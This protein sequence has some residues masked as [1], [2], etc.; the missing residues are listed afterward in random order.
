MTKL[1]TADQ[2]LSPEAAAERVAPLFERAELA[3]LELC[4]RIAMAPM[5]RRLAPDDRVP[6]QAI[7][8]YYARRASGGVGLIITEGTHVDDQHAPDSENVPG[9]FNDE[10]ASGWKRVIEAVHSAENTFGSPSRIAVQLWHTGRHAMNPIGP[11]PIPVQKRDGGYKDT[12]RQMTEADMD[13]VVGIF[14]NAARLSIEAGFDSM[15]IHG[16]HGYLLDSFLSP[17]SNQRTDDYGGSFENRMRFPLR[18][19]RAVRAVIDEH[20]GPE[21]PLMIRFSQ[22]RMEDYA[23]YAYPDPEHLERWVLALKE[24]GIDILHVSTRDATDPGF[25]HLF[26]T[27]TE[28]GRR[29][30]A[31]WTR[32]LSGGMPTVA[33]G[34]V[35]VSASMDEGAAVQT[36]DPAPVAGLITRGEADMIAVGRSLI[37]NPRW[38]DIVKEGRWSELVPYTRE[39]LETL[40][41]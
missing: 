11:S 2:D 25:P 13:E 24:A 10:Q 6:S 9:I 29:T 34:R 31:G 8:D 35:S 36:T 16:A 39:M 22:W 14:E 1:P 21:Y 33:V 37:A 3:G 30:L 17:A 26:D 5:T 40:D 7:A 41:D 23:A 19:V 18:V 27:D 38:C 32:K 20:A 28:D 4:N 15:E 12:P